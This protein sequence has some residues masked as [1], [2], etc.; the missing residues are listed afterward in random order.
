M[1]FWEFT[2]PIQIKYAESKYDAYFLLASLL[3]DK[4]SKKLQF[5]EQGSVLQKSFMLSV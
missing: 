4:N 5:F 2:L 1:D 3:H